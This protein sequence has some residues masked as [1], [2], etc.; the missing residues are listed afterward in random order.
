MAAEFSQINRAAS[1]SETVA[2]QIKESILNGIYGSGDA[3]PSENTLAEQFGVSRVVIREALKDLKSKG[4]VETRR[5]PKGGPF[6]TQLDRLTLGEQ[7]SDLVRLRKMTVAQL[8]QARLL[9]EPE[10]V[11]LALQQITDAQ[12]RELREQEARAGSA[13]DV[14]KR[15][16]FNLDFH[17]RLGQLSGNPFYIMLM[18]SFMDFVDRFISVINPTTHNLHEGDSHLEIIEALAARDEA[19]ALTLVRTHLVE[20]RDRLM[21]LEREFLTRN[22]A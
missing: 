16:M 14:Q 6:V 1:L 15:K 12:I 13:R 8:Y 22:E 20:T 2:A 3:L 4:L 21:A 10:V 19:K 7:F 17:R 9:I 18:D 11:R 5:G